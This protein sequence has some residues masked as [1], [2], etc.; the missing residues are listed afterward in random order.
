[1]SLK[2]QRKAAQD[3]GKGG[4]LWVEAAC[5]C[6]WAPPI[7]APG[8]RRDLV[9]WFPQLQD[10]GNGRSCPTAVVRRQWTET[11]SGTYKIS[12]IVFKMQTANEYSCAS[13]KK[14]K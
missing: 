12:A 11:L 4:G 10:E 3:K 13:L 2:K 5:L 1:M 6:I 9:P 8:Q 14:Y 7:A